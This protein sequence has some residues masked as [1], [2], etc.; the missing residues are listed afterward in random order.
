MSFFESVLS[1]WVPDSLFRSLDFPS[2]PRKRK[3][4]LADIANSFLVTPLTTTK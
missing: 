3:F 4:Q 2:S 1:G